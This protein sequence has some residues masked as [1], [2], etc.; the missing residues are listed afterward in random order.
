MG[1]D[2]VRG[3]LKAC[4]DSATMRTERRL[5]G[6]AN[7]ALI[8]VRVCAYWSW[9]L[10]FLVLRWR[11]IMLWRRTLDGATLH[12]EREVGRTVCH[13]CRFQQ[14]CG[15][16]MLF[17]KPCARS[18]PD[19]EDIPAACTSSGA[20]RILERGEW[21]GDLAGACLF[22][23]GLCACIMRRCVGIEGRAA[24]VRLAQS[25]TFAA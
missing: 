5:Y 9:W 6:V 10:R 15:L 20:V 13:S 18:C 8:V 21:E 3:I 2:V 11:A 12:L 23:F 16:G 17:P 24:I 19:V 22:S 1:W 7:A 14:D 4:I 25:L